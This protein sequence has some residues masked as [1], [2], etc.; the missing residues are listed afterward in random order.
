MADDRTKRGPQDAARVN[1][2]ED[3]EVRYWAEKWGVSR[4]ELEAAVRQAGTGADAVAR[5]LGK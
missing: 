1:I 2:N 4:A 5:A 3:Y